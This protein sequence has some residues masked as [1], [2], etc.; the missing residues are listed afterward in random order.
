MGP[1]KLHLASISALSIFLYVFAHT[2][3]AQAFPV[4]DGTYPPEAEGPAAESSDMDEQLELTPG[5]QPRVVDVDDYRA[6][7]DAGDHTEVNETTPTALL[8]RIARDFCRN[9][10]PCGKNSLNFPD[11]ADARY[12]R[13]FRPGR[14][15]AT[16][17]ITHPCS[18]CRRG[19]PTS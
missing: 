6:R 4:A 12:R 17:P 9:A 16:P 1:R 11:A 10:A 15:P 14:R 13:F 5:P 19:R 3:S 18:S 8:S 7:A 2:N